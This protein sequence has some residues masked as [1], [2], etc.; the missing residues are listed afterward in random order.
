MSVLN[1]SG[2]P[3][4]KI[5]SETNSEIIEE[6]ERILGLARN[7]RLAGIAIAF[8]DDDLRTTTYFNFHKGRTTL[9]GSASSLLHRM[10]KAMT[11]DE[12]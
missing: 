10:N 3:V 2:E 7:G 8:I 9:I 6:L 5:I 11:D 12:D 1:F 4:D